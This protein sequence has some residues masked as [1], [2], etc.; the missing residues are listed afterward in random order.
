LGFLGR[1]EGQA[2]TQELPDVGAKNMIYLTIIL[3]ERKTTTG[4]DT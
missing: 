4:K 2:K 1:A 3:L